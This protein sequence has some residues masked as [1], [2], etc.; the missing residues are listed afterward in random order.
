MAWNPFKS[1]LRDSA[2]SF[3]HNEDVATYNEGMVEGTAYVPPS[4]V[5]FDDP[6]QPAEAYVVVTYPGGSAEDLPQFQAAEPEQT[7]EYVWHTGFEQLVQ[8]PQ[9]GYNQMVHSLTTPED[10]GGTTGEARTPF[11]AIGP[12]GGTDNPYLGARAIVP[13]NRPGAYGPVGGGTDYNHQ[14]ASAYF[15]NEAASVAQR[16]SEVAMIAAS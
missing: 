12:V 13:T 16:Y 14:L 7:G 3:A 11:S 6:A 2:A 9:P 10:I 15:A 8:G 4:T 5:N 1:P